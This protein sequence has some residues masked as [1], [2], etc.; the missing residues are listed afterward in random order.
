MG[1]FRIRLKG[2]STANFSCKSRF[3]FVIALIALEKDN[4]ID[5]NCG[6]DEKLDGWCLES[7]HM[8]QLNE[9]PSLSIVGGTL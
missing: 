4:S 5:L 9:A 2:A 8:F 3:I 6:I 1:A 7:N